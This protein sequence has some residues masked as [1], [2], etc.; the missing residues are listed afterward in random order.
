MKMK[1]AMVNAYGKAIPW[2]NELYE[3]KIYIFYTNVYNHYFR[4]LFQNTF[5]VAM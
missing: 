2:K 4:T 1:V 3:F 5:I